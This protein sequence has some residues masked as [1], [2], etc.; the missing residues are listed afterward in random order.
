MIDETSRRARLDSLLSEDPVRRTSGR[1]RRPT[2]APRADRS[3]STDV[4][5]WVESSRA[6]SRTMGVLLLRSGQRREQA[7]HHGRGRRGPE[8]RGRGSCSSV[9]DAAFVVC[10]VVAGRRRTSMWSEQLRGL[11]AE[12]VV[13]LPVF[14]WR[15]PEQM[16]PHYLF[17][18]PDT[19]LGYRR[20]DSGRPTGCSATTNP[21]SSSWASWSG[22]CHMDYQA[23]ADACLGL[24]YF[25]PGIIQLGEHERFVDCGAFDG[26]TLR[27]FLH[28]S[29]GRLTGSTR[30]SPTRTPSTAERGTCVRAARRDRAT[31]QARGRPQWAT[32]SARSI[33]RATVDERKAGRRVARSRS[34]ACASTTLIDSATYVKMDIEGAETEAILGAARLLV[35]SQHAT[36]CLAVPH[37][38]RL[39]PARQPRPLNQA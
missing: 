8:S 39:L 28:E 37:A 24:Q 7:G 30:S 15:Y 25:E 20:R 11:G 36:R 31:D 34:D 10:E 2:A 18:L 9:S 5:R 33:S 3:C 4:G 12:V 6:C 29:G 14:V 1:S 16:L 19:L 38:D 13:P 21:A 27:A 32:R 22:A 35:G 26:D 17:A 23:L